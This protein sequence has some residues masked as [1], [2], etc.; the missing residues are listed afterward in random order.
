MQV[1]LKYVTDRLQE[2]PAVGRSRFLRDHL[3]AAA[4]TARRRPLPEAGL[5][6]A[7]INLGA[8]DL[9]AFSGH[10]QGDEPWSVV[11]SELL[12]GHLQGAGREP[13]P[14]K[15]EA[16]ESADRNTWMRPEQRLF[17][18]GL[19]EALA[20]NAVVL[21][22]AATG[23]GKGRAVAQAVEDALASGRERVVVTGP[24]LGVL[25]ALSQEFASCPGMDRAVQFFLG[26]AQ[27]FH[28]GRAGQLADM[29]QSSSDQVVR[30][31]GLEL[32]QWLKAGAP[33]GR[34]S[35]TA[36]FAAAQ[37]HSLS[38]LTDDLATFLPEGYGVDELTLESGEIE[39]DRKGETDAGIRAALLARDVD[40]EAQVVFCTHAMYALHARLMGLERY[41]LPPHE[42]VV[43]DEAHQFE[44]SV[45]SVLSP[46][47]SLDR[48]PSLLRALP[49]AI[50]K[51]GKQEVQAIEDAL[52]MLRGRFPDCGGDHL[53]FPDD[54]GYAPVQGAV[55]RVLSSLDA[56]LARTDRARTHPAD[57]ATLGLLKRSRSV[58]RNAMGERALLH[59]SSSPVR[60]YLSLAASERG[61]RSLFVRMW[62]QVDAVALI[63]ATLYVPTRDARRA[64]V[65]DD[66][67][68]HSARH[69]TQVLALPHERV[70]YL[71]PVRP[72]WVRGNV[73]AHLT[74]DPARR[75][76]SSSGLDQD[77]YAQALE[78]W[79]DDTAYDIARIAEAANSGTLVLL[80]AYRDI[81]GL[82]RRLTPILE[83]RLLTQSE[84]RLS[85][86]QEAF[87]AL[88][89]NDH[90]PVWLATGAAWTGVNLT[91]NGEGQVSDLV[92]AR[93]P[94]GMNRSIAQ[95]I[96]SRGRS[97][98][99]SKVSEAYWQTAQ[100]IGR[101]VRSPRDTDRRL[102]VLDSRAVNERLYTPIRL[103][104]ESYRQG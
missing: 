63:S 2:V 87:L 12:H 16:P 55:V 30:D 49:S 34:T 102:W 101:M 66:S 67:G 72:D 104:L 27:F 41:L 37:N 14:K 89:Q 92:I 93:L 61:S 52:E 7:S 8:R 76:P 1:R 80:T 31:A 44:S 73:I 39:E 94:V 26:A 42:V 64:T 59:L 51:A 4:E 45:H 21:A 28:A 56:L 54:S 82:T 99:E 75:P 88:T 77:E 22:E 79:L 29:M 78:A 6:S 74:R 53:L 11:L 84:G 32:E 85:Q 38:H 69:L 13:T 81:E 10:R 25:A 65:S 68:W 96:R 48:L 3:H 58:L 50:R 36:A 71:P 43:I 98:F 62:D 23:T 100:G 35:S 91:A 15:K 17:Y 70:R 83:G 60:G 33:T 97:S 9:A 95:A 24:T 46:S 90:R 47:T 57:P 20:A 103:L 18:S 86:Q 5:D 19:T 40:G